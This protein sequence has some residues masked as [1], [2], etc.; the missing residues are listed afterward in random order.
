[1][2]QPFDFPL[3]LLYSL[4]KSFE[5]PF[6]AEYL[7]EVLRLIQEGQVPL[8]GFFSVIKPGLKIM[9]FFGYILTGNFPGTSPRVSISDITG[10][11]QA[12]GTRTVVLPSPEWRI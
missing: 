5:F 2:R 7:L 12:A 3:Q 1:M 11:K 4:V 9:I 10:L 6:D 8:P